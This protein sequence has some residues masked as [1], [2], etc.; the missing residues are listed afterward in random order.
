MLKKIKK[1]FKRDKKNNQ[2]NDFLKVYMT[3]I[4]V[5]RFLYFYNLYKLTENI[6]GDIVECGVGKGI[7]FLILSHIIKSE[8][9]NKNIWGFDSFEGFPEPSEEDI[10]PRSVKKGQYSVS[11]DKINKMINYYL[12]DDVFIRSK[13]TLVKG[14]F[15]KTLNETS[16]DKISLLNLD[17]DLYESYKICL[18]ELYPR[19]S[20]GGIVTFDEYIRESIAYPG[21][22]KAINDFFKDKDVEFKKD[23]YFGK[24][25]VVNKK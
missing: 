17:V 23:N 24:Y 7:S 22:M 12:N 18:E 4:N 3:D 16:P 20:I 10:S 1:I 21:A 25:Y 2:N 13:I 19:L 14:F 6:E 11:I 8:K 15:E 5:A 9:S